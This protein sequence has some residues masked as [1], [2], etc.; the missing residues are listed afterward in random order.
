[1]DG[2]R[3][4]AAA[5][6][7]ISFFLC[8][9]LS[10]GA[11]EASETDLEAAG[12]RITDEAGSELV[13]LSL[14]DSSV[15][16]MVAGSWK[17]SLGVNWGVAFTPF[18]AQAFSGDSPLLFAQE[19]DLTLSLW[20]RDRWFVEGSFVDDYSLNTYRA[21]Y[22]GVEGE[23]VQY[24]GVGN[25]GLDFPA[26][27]YLDL[28]GGAPS[29]LGVYG[30]FGVRDLTLHGL[31]RYDA[32]VR[33]ERIYSGNRERT[34]GYADLSRPLRGR[35]FVLP[36]ENLE[37]VP[38]VYIQDTGGAYTDDKGRRWRLAEPSEYAASARYGLVELSLGTYTGGAEE[39]PGMI[40]AAYSAGGSTNPWILSLG[41]YGAPG[42]GGGSKF[43]G[44]VQAYFDLS[45]KKIT[46]K[47]YPQSG[48]GAPGVPGTVR[49][50]GVDALVIY[51][52]GTFSPFERRSRYHAQWG[53]STEAALV[54]LSTGEKVKG[55]EVFSLED[56]SASAGVSSGQEETRRSVYELVSNTASPSGREA[57]GRWPLAASSAAGAWPELY[58]PGKQVFSGDLGIRFTSY[59]AAEAFFIGT[60]VVP[61]SVQVFRGGV[62]DPRFSY[63]PSAGTVTLANPPGFNEIIRITYL[64]RGDERRTG[65]FAAG[66]GALWES[67]GPF[68]S[69][70]GLGL[71]WNVEGGAYSEAGTSSPGTVGLG[72]E[73][74]WDYSR[75]KAGLTLGLGFE[76]PDT[77]GLYRAAG[78]EGN[79][80]VL[81]LPPGDSFISEVPASPVL[82][83]TSLNAGNRAPLV[84]RDYRETSLLGTSSLNDIESN[85]GA[86]SGT[87]GPYPAKDR[88]FSAQ[89]LAAEFKLTKDEYWTGFETAL[90]LDGA[91]L[92][93]AK[94]IV[95]PYRLYGFSNDSVTE[96]LTVVFQAGSLAG[97]DSGNPENPDLVWEEI[98]FNGTANGGNDTYDTYRWPITFSLDDTD[99]RRLQNAKYLRILVYA[100]GLGTSETISGRVL[101]APPV[102]RGAGFRPV[103]IN[104]NEV[105]LAEDAPE[106]AGIPSV[107]VREY[108]DIVP[109]RLEN[110]YG[111]IISRLHSDGSH[112]R[113]LET[114]W[115]DLSSETGPGADARLGP[116]PLSNYRI[117]SFFLRRPKAKNESEQDELNKARFRFFLGRGPQSPGNSRETAVDASFPLSAFDAPGVNVKPGQWA[118]IE[119]RY[120]GDDQGIYIEGTKAADGSLVYNPGVYGASG[121][122][123]QAGTRTSYLAF[124]VTPDPAS[125]LPNG[126]MAVDEVILEESAPSYRLNTGGSVEWRLPGTLV[127]VKGTPVISDLSLGAALESGAQGDPFNAGAPALYGM[128]SSV[129]S[130]VSVLGAR[131]SGNFSYTFNTGNSESGAENDFVW[132]AG[133]GL[134]RSW[135]SFSV[136]ETFNDAP[137]D[138]AM[139]HRFSL[140]FSGVFR[141]S[142]SGEVFYNDERLNRRWNAEMGL[143]PR[144]IPLD[145]SL[146]TAAAWTENTPEPGKNLEN[147]GLAWIDSWKPLVPDWGA[148]ASSR[149]G[150]GSFAA[151][152]RTEPLGATMTLEG[153]SGY[154]GVSGITQTLSLGRLDFPWTPEWGNRK[155]RFLFRGEREFRRDLFSQGADFRDEFRRWG[156]SLDDS[157][158]L[159]FFPP[160][161]S[162]GS[163]GLGNR[164][165]KAN[166]SFP[167]GTA[168][169]YSRFADRF[170]ASLR[171]PESYG[172][173]SFFIPSVISARI[174]RTLERK[175]DTPLDT[176]GLGAAMRFQA[177]NMFGAFGAAPLF[178]FYRSDEFS[179][180]VEGSAA[181]PKGEKTSWSLRAGQTMSFHGFT[182]A[183]LA[184][185]NALAVSSSSSASRGARWT[186]SLTLKWIVPLEKSLLSFVYDGIMGLARRQS[187]WLTLADIA[188]SEY[189]RLRVETLEFA[190]EHES[191]S[192]GKAEYTR[193]SIILGH[194]SIVRIAGRLNLSVFAKLNGSEDFS[195]RIFSFLGTLGTTLS[196]TF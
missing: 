78:M 115:G 131:V 24:I 88:N 129:Q 66:V 151:S 87:N 16:L 27:P 174:N 70:V 107:A 46:L 52:P 15:S 159:L 123:D 128:N 132:R 195:T 17:G 191:A 117:L 188:E 35:S 196:A 137:E 178:R 40:A 99:R 6:F 33:E 170:E 39:P 150:K 165:A 185:D 64:K 82:A 67:D 45:G 108:P 111:D 85:P 20:I 177:V 1:M 120:R 75:L 164:M 44:E 175:M 13:N 55:F 104:D 172:L 147:Y 32:A 105:N 149:D 148:G 138:K 130:E 113:I 34:Y 193:F 80:I 57:A 110:K 36:E 12:R 61:G 166:S 127:S 69:G 103:T 135:G 3:S 153:S 23:P 98:L 114:A 71:R 9:G 94:E 167:D 41:S 54:R 4:T 171:M 90:G 63:S 187:S 76:Q 179:H 126:I 189:E 19:V 7:F 92:E 96:K 192:G 146:N 53:G 142:L 144:N 95:I 101:L 169:S 173:P 42:S 136:S 58:V 28:G 112:Q 152:L 2:L 181:F 60:D 176:L 21:G 77:A 30:R 26:F 106:A 31:V 49:I 162:L 79:E 81:S 194:E 8:P 116:V 109:P 125:D 84:Y 22:Q 122:P 168:L 186:D 102:V 62:G 74:R 68:S 38:V 157:L 143:K 155:Y 11:Q 72:A 154:T 73:A 93:R 119:L 124:F 183:E 18:G 91:I 37:T 56:S 140:N 48:G 97:K 43:L 141:S 10:L 100:A 184:I 65:S 50:N 59:G 5:V 163:P 139:D 133:H 180:T 161:Y 83:P 89:I 182:G 134:S 14:G 156:E 190:Y 118:K 86:V 51:E 47:D 160:F 145:V 158:P 29:S 25:T 121:S